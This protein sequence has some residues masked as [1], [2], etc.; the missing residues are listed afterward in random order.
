[1]YPMLNYAFLSVPFGWHTVRYYLY[2]V[3]VNGSLTFLFRLASSDRVPPFLYIYLAFTSVLFS[4]YFYKIPFFKH[5]TS[6]MVK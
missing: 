2:C 5:L 6:V 4:T 1:M 3:V